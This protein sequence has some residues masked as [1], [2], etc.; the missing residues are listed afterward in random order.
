MKTTFDKLDIQEIAYAVVKEIKPLL[1]Q[2]N[3][4]ID[5]SLLTKEQAA[6]FLNVKPSWLDNHEIP[7]KCKL[8]GHVRYR[9]SKLI[10]W[11]DEQEIPTT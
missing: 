2:Q 9:K 10:K 5:D 7:G 1:K 3:N 11:I 6:E 4:I 8:M